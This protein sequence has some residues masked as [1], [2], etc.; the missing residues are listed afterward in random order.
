MFK[1]NRKESPGN[2]N[3]IMRNLR[4]VCF[5]MYN[6]QAYYIKAMRWEG[7]VTRMWSVRSA[8]RIVVRNRSG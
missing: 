6:I 4:I 5:T 1:S 8:Y 7:H 2:G 3:Y